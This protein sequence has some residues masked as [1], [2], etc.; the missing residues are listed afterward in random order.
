MRETG[1]LELASTITLVLQANQLSKCGGSKITPRPPILI[2]LM[3]VSF[4]K[5]LLFFDENSTFTQSN[6][7]TA[8]LKNI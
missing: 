8:E 6:I 2:L 7:V 4:C 3:S 5:K 1:G